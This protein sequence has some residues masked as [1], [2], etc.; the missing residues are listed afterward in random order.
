METLLSAGGSGDSRNFDLQQLMNLMGQQA[1]NVNAMFKHVNAMSQQLGIVAEDVKVMKSEFQE[2]KNEVNSM[3][4]NERIT[5]AQAN[6]I[7]AYAGKRV[8][9][10]LS[11]PEKRS[12]WTNEDYLKYRKYSSGVYG[13]LYRE[14]KRKG[15]LENPLSETKKCNF[16]SAL[17]DI[18]A[19]SPASGKSELFAEIDKKAVANKTAR[20]MGY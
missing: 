16:Q 3:K 5:H 19:W 11:L 1:M 12:E 18:E 14:V 10:F 17:D 2:V 4:E 13:C 20:E 7:K 15:H 9:S 6:Q 8:F